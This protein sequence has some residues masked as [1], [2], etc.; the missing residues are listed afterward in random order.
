MK[1]LVEYIAKYLVDKPEQVDVKEIDGDSLN[2]IEV[3][4]A[5]EDSGKVI[6]REGRIANAIRTIV[7]A[8]AAKQQKKVNVEIIT[9]DKQQGGV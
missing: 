2:V 9:E 1:E 6:G 4:T 3:K 7:K 8:A 5:P